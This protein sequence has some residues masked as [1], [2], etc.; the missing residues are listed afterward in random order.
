MNIIKL[1]GSCTSEGVR[2][3]KGSV[4]KVEQ[5]QWECHQLA[6]QTAGGV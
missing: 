2:D 3:R 6:E 1:K 5:I 4:G